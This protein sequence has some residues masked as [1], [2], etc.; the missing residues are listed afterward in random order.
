MECRANHWLQNTSVELRHTCLVKKR[1]WTRRQ[2]RRRVQKQKTHSASPAPSGFRLPKYVCTAER[3]PGG[4]G[5]RA[6][7]ASAALAYVG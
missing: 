5:W 2:A 3:K 1:F 4:S 7:V 6:S